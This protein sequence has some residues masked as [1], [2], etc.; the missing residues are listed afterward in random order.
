M[1]RA[2]VILLFLLTS[3]FVVYSQN[4]AI[5][6]RDTFFYNQLNSNAKYKNEK[7][8]FNVRIVR[9]K[10]DSIS[11]LIIIQNVSKRKMAFAVTSRSIVTYKKGKKIGLM[12]FGYD[13]N[14]A[15]E[16][17][18]YEF[19]MPTILPNQSDTLHITYEKCDKYAIDIFLC[20]DMDEFIRRQAKIRNAYNIKNDNGKE[21]YLLRQLEN[22]K[23]IF[24]GIHFDDISSNVTSYKYFKLCFTY[25]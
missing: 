15:L 21:I 18:M 24:T 3:T 4:A 16:E 17:I 23:G 9:E 12:S 10:S 20:T 25:K 8:Q 6:K 1:Q 14:P 19:E 5:I 11:I 7:K 13:S 22:T 2:L